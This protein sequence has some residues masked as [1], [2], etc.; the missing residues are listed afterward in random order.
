MKIKNPILF[1]TFL[2]FLVV[3]IA[4]A[5]TS[6]FILDA[7]A[8]PLFLLTGNIWG[9]IALKFA[10]VFLIGFFVVRNIYDTN[11]N[12]YTFVL[13]IVLGIFLVGIGVYSNIWGMNNPE[14]LEQSA[15]IP[16]EE[17]LK[18]YGT[19]ITVIYFLPMAFSLGAFKLYDMSKGYV[20]FIRPKKK[21][22]DK[23]WKKVKNIGT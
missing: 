4:D 19:M 8:N 5:I 10:V 15:S 18:A 23:M 20:S 3:N 12:Y 21:W 6:F 1:Y 11:F 22:F 13:I 14:G 16:Q 7:E 17:K 2:V 9:V